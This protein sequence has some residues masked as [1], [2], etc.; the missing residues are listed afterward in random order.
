MNGAWNDRFVLPLQPAVVNLCALK[1][2]L[3]AKRLDSSSHD[4]DSHKHL[5]F[6]NCHLTMAYYTVCNVHKCVL[7]PRLSFK[8]SVRLFLWRILIKRIDFH[9]DHIP[10]KSV[11]WLFEAPFSVLCAHWFGASSF[12]HHAEGGRCADL[13][14]LS[15]GAAGFRFA[16]HC[17]AAPA[18]CLF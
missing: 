8:P 10:Q 5:F 4:L 14:L 18:F 16:C 11:A 17:A 7:P 6:F 3:E 15:P 1:S 13:I 12:W 9:I 2:R